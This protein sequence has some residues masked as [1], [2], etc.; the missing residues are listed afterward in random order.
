MFRAIKPPVFRFWGFGRICLF[1]SEHGIPENTNRWILRRFESKLRT[2]GGG[3][4]VKSE[5]PERKPLTLNS[6]PAR[7][8]PDREVAKTAMQK[9]TAPSA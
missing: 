7:P 3:G 5:S 1:G 8:I 4:S 6:E 2:P 9:H